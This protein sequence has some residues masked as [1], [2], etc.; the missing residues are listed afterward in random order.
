MDNPFAALRNS[1]I[2]SISKAW[3]LPG[4][5][6]HIQE[7]EVVAVSQRHLPVFGRVADIFYLDNCEVCFGLKTLNRYQKKYRRMVW[8]GGNH[9]TKTGQGMVQAVGKKT[10]ITQAFCYPSHSVDIPPLSFHQPRPFRSH[11]STWLLAG[12]PSSSVG[13]SSWNAHLSQSLAKML[14]IKILLMSLANQGDSRRWIIKLQMG[15]DSSSLL[16]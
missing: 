4:N 7:Q 5:S 2:S 10:V 3:R 15:E 11:N 9:C 12:E 6:L 16:G 8:R 14:R 1:G 13:V